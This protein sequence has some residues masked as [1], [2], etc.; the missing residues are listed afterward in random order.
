MENLNNA[1][2]AGVSSVYGVNMGEYRDAVGSS[3]M[4]LM[5]ALQSRGDGE[6]IMRGP[7]SSFDGH[8]AEYL[9]PFVKSEEGC[10]FPGNRIE[11]HREQPAYCYPETE[12]AHLASQAVTSFGSHA[13][14]AAESPHFSISTRTPSTSAS[15]TEEEADA[16]KA[17]IM[18]HPKYLCLL[19]A[20]INCQKVGAPPD[21][22]ARLDAVSKD[23]ENRQNRTTI[24]VGMD[25]E[26]DRFMEAYHEMLIKY[27]EELTKP[28]KEA[29]AFFRKIETQLNSVTKGTIRISPPA[30]SDEKTEG[31]GFS[32]EEDCSTGEMEYEEVDHN[33]EERELKDR[34]LRKYSGYLSSLKQ[35][36][37]KKKKKGKLPKDARQKLLDWWNLHYKWPYPSETE[38]VALAE[39]TGLDQKQI[40][41]W[42]INQ[43]KRHWKPSDDMPFVVMDTHTPHGAA[44]YV[45]RHLMPD[46]SA[47]H[48]DC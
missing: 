3:M 25:P 2:G 38:K 19:E 15:A 22:V 5:T 39:C 11:F 37:M 18:A 1:A 27:H 7:Y 4:A 10:G 14:E 30:E 17:K 24:D 28:F 42:F 43:R 32:E 40:N 21:V 35:E 23:Y 16:V 29:M 12:S 20:Y 34:L 13:R 48:L 6:N 47:F 9:V 33:S 44:F 36:F 45:E 41:N 31:G 26:L 46:G 8:A